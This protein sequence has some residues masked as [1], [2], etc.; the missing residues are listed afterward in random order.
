MMCVHWLNCMI[1]L[2]LAMCQLTS[3]IITLVYKFSNL[4]ILKLLDSTPSESR[5][6]RG[7]TKNAA[8]KK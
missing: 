7:Q 5:A 4:T 1:R 3:T 8:N 6:P 2:D